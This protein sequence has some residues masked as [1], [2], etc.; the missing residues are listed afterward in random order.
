MDPSNIHIIEEKNN[1][2]V[3]QESNEPQESTC[4]GRKFTRCS[5][6]NPKTLFTICLIVGSILLLA[7][8]LAL[9]GYCAPQAAAGAGQTLKSALTFVSTKMGTDPFLL[10]CFTAAFGTAFTLTGAIGLG[11]TKHQRHPD[12][13]I[14]IDLEKNK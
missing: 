13:E 11:I 14:T 10:A 12:K 2:P 8:I 4:C 3:N 6:I 1:S 9:A 5:C 7:G